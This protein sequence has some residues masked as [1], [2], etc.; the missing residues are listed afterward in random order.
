MLTSDTLLRASNRDLAGLL[1]SGHALQ[2]IDLAGVSYRGIALGLPWWVER[3]SW[4]TFAKEFVHDP[5]LG[6]VRGWNVRVEQTG[7]DG[8][9][10]PKVQNGAPFT[11]GHYR[12]VPGCGH[13]PLPT[14]PGVLLDYGLG[15]N[16]ALQ[17]FNRARDPLVA[18]AP[19]DPSRL[20][21]WTYMEFLGRPWRTP[22][23][24]VLE[25][26]G[27]VAHVPA[28]PRPRQT[29]ALPA[30]QARADLLRGQISAARR[31]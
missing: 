20:L 1:A 5:A 15:G 27:V 8:P 30:P 6:C 18:L 31:V 29:A 13:S 25:R 4:K 24:F 10:V 14:G 28:V 19:G 23:W 26:V 12:V 17:L 16:P 22:S 9:V 21:G 3:L 7:V 2:P 11:F